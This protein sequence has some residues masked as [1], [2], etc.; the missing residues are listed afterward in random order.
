MPGPSI[1]PARSRDQVKGDAAAVAHHVADRDFT[2]DIGVE[3]GEAGQVLDDGVVEA[4]F[5]GTHHR[6]YGRGRD[7]FGNRGELK[8]GVGIHQIRLAHFAH[9]KAF[10]VDHLVLE[11]DA[12]RDAGYAAF[13][14]WQP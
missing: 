13:F 12:D 11:H 9:A 7:G 2:G 4:G 6:G 1:A 10:Q 5:A 14:S 3:Q 8:Y